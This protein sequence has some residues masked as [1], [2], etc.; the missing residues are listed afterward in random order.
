MTAIANAIREKTGGTDALTLDAMV[1]AIAGLGGGSNGGGDEASVLDS[2]IDGSIT[3]ILS[4]ASSLKAYIFLDSSQLKKASFP[5]ATKIYKEAFNGCSALE[6]INFP[7]LRELSG[8]KTFYNCILLK[9]VYFPSF[10]GR[11]GHSANNSAGS[12]AFYSCNSLEIARFYKPETIGYNAFCAC[13][14]LKA[15]IIEAN[16]LCTLEKNNAFVNSS[17]ESGTGFIYVPSA[18]VET[19]KAATNWSIYGTQFRALEDYTVDGTITGELDESK[20]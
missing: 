6:E 18:L 3:E 7:L 8:T 16:E 14:N 17:I 19:Y 11:I 13:Y 9:K 15:L 20:I 2:L 12:Q 10:I 1:E 5:L 4:N